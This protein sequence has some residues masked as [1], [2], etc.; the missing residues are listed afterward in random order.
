VRLTTKLLLLVASIITLT[1]VVN[2]TLLN[3]E[4]RGFLQQSQLEWV[5]TLAEG[6]SESV[7]QDT[8]DGNKLKV[9]ALL[10]KLVIT[11]DAIVYVFVTDMDGQLLAHSFDSGFPRFLADRIKN[12]TDILYTGTQKG[13]YNTKQGPIIEYDAPLIAGMVG[14]LH[15]GLNQ[16]EVNTL[17]NQVSRKMILLLSLVGLLGTGLAFLI[18]RRINLPLSRFTEQLHRNDVTDEINF[19]EIKS[20]D[21][22]IQQMVSTFQTIM[23]AR[24]KLGTELKKNEQNLS[25]TLNSIGDAVITT[26]AK[27]NVTRMNPV[28]ENLTGWSLQEA[29][30][31]SLKTVF[32][33]VNASTRDA[34]ENPVDKVIAT[35]EI[36]YLSN[37]TTLIS[38]NGTEYQIADSAA[39]IRD[40]DHILG[41]V[42]VFNDVTE[43]Y[44]L[45][46]EIRSSEQHLKL[47]REQAPMA[48]IE[49]NTDFQVL[50]WNK[51][52]E[53]MFGYTVGEVKGRDFVNFMLP[54]GAIVDVKQIWKELMAQTGGELSL[55]ENLTKDGRV[56]LCEWHNTP[57]K[58]ESGNVIGAA[59]I[60][61]DITQRQQQDEQLRRSQK[62]DALGKLT[63]GI[64]HDYNNMLGVILGYSEL[65]EDM[66]HEQPE[67]TQYIHQIKHA[68]ERGAKLTKKLLAFSRQ[69]SSEN[70]TVNLNTL[71][72]DSQLM[73]E[74]TMTVR[75]SLTFELEKALWLINIDVSDLEDA[76]LNMSI[77]AMHAIE[78]IGQVTFET[79]NEVINEID[80]QQLQLAAGEYVL[81]S[82]TD[83]G[84]GMDT[85][86]KEKIFD[87][88]YSTKGEL[89]TGLGLSQVYGLVHRSNGNIKVHSEP[90]HGSR[91]TLYFPRYFESEIDEKPF[92]DEEI[93]HL[94]GNQTILVVDDEPALANLTS[95]ILSQQGYRVFSANCG[96]EALIILEKEHIDLLLSDV[97]MP[98]MDGYQL[99]AVVHEKY[100]S[101]KIQLA[102]GFS[103]DRHIDNINVSLHQDLLHKPYH[104]KKLLL[105]IREL[106]NSS[107]K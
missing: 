67:L 88:F 66:A 82:I 43:Q 12:D 97:I 98:E 2:I 100:P 85:E 52:A 26:D 103:D 45:R 14:K 31:Q 91:F 87:P 13:I 30:G 5:D 57:L 28:A 64:A 107:E 72:Q 65:I 33:I 4:V 75:I 35:G 69:Q 7:A 44:K 62:M 36:L 20:S 76:I 46:E 22:D 92:E 63:G 8:I 58:D 81:L 78:G 106:I 99:A 50:D 29:Q 41:M 6:V 17:L 24:A 27:G 38:K 9:R 77:N 51:A 102:S 11:D 19:P 104:S 84:C 3:I 48:T 80:A 83:T 94:S 32:P 54:E 59:S 71:L 70:T 86:T 79:R 61:Q 55:N 25:L 56:I 21:P 74:K 90:E 42:L 95:H 89:G 39:P 101:I 40:N 18:G 15:L 23:T 47:Y 93:T 1:I 60:V 53:K 73:L 34:I 16:S 37:H 10:R 105:R 49:W 96:E 68:G